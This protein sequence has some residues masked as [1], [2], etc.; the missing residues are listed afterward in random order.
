MAYDSVIFVVLA[1][2][3]AA[4]MLA[5]LARKTIQAVRG[6]PTF[7][8]WEIR[9]FERQD[10]RNMPP[11]GGIVFTGSSSI[12]FWKTLREDMAPLPVLNR[13][14]GGSQIH[15][16]THYAD[17]IILPYEPG[18]V[19]LYA[20]ENDIAGVKFSR[21]KTAE[22]ILE[23][24]QAFCKTV[25]ARLPETPIYFVSIKPPKQRASLWPEMQKANRLINAFAATDDRIR[26]VD[27][28]TAMLDPAG[29]PRDDLYKWDGLHINA[30]GYV[31]WTSIL[32]PVLEKT[33]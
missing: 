1:T 23:A 6:D 29:Q 2:V 21:K 18:A 30:E 22:E 3:F 17:R 5:I 19:V 13:G 31:I 4:S 8:E 33:A 32:K 11:P 15:Q 14:F 7:W 25:H 26:Y 9:R 12:R 24:F 27:V 16:V 28:A 10:R 20:G